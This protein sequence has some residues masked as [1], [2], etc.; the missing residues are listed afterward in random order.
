M[1][2]PTNPTNMGSLNSKRRLSVPTITTISVNIETLS[3]DEEKIIPDLCKTNDC[4]I[5]CLQETL[6]EAKVKPE[7]KLELCN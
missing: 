1:N 4:D 3:N 7:Q 6:T 2:K 5:L